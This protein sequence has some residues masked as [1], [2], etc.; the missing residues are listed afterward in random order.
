MY[1]IENEACIALSNHCRLT[2][3]EI[4]FTINSLK[5]HSSGQYAVTFA[6]TGCKLKYDA[7]RNLFWVHSYH[8]SE[9]DVIFVYDSLNRIDEYWEYLKNC[10]HFTD[11]KIEDR[12]QF[13]K[14]YRESITS[15]LS[16]FMPY[17]F[18]MS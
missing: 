9:F 2:E 15:Q 14:T 17:L 7:E 5:D 16:Y 4:Q 3:K 1:L 11:D 12:K 8:Y 6:T 18:R 10:L 13:Y